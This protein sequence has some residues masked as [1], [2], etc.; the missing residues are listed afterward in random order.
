MKE[1]KGTS[2]PT[3]GRGQLNEKTITSMQN[4]YGMAIRQI[5]N[6]KYEMKKAIGT[7]LFHC[8]DITDAE[9][10]Y[11]FCPPGE[12]SWC[13]YKKDI[14]TGKSTYK[15]TINLPKWIYHIIQ[16]VFD[17]LADDELLSKC[18]SG[19]AQNPNEVFNNIFWTGCPKTIYIS[20]SIIEL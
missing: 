9:S 15:K 16:P 5:L 10:R 17:A 2:T 18:F 4:F 19:E 20:R 6:N 8:I 7:I 12:G 14:L 3:G 1:Y 13:K 11:G